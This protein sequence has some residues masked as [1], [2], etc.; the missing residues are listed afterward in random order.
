M[1]KTEFRENFT[2]LS[3]AYPQRLQEAYDNNLGWVENH[4]ISAERQMG[5]VWDEAVALEYYHNVKRYFDEIMA[6]FNA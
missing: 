4:L 2:K 6:N 3:E 1:H 5:G